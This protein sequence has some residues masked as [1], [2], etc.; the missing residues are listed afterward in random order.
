MTFYEND[1]MQ[2]GA[3]FL[4]NDLNIG[5]F[6]Y[7]MT[8]RQKLFLFLASPSWSCFYGGG[9]STCI[10]APS[11]GHLDYMQGWRLLELVLGVAGVNGGGK[12]GKEKVKVENTPTSTGHFFMCFLPCDVSMSEMGKICEGIN[13]R[14]VFIPEDR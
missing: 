2:S 5:V 1:S 13:W 3:V 4:A 8:L 10:G 9:V 12:W 11:T 14:W 7:G 6:W